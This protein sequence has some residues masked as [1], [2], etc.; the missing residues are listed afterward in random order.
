MATVVALAVLGVSG[1]AFT[2]SAQAPTPLPPERLSWYGDPGA[3]DVSGIWVRTGSAA[4]LTASGAQPGSVEGWTPWPPPL[5]QA[6]L[7]NWRTRVADNAAGNRTDDPVSACLPPGMPR[8]IT[9][10]NSP[11]QIIQTPGRVV[12][13][14]DGAPIRRIWL[15]GRPLPKLDD[16]ESFSNGTASGRYESKDLVIDTAGLKDEPIDSTGVPHSDE[17]RITERYRRTDATTLS[18]EVTL[19]DPAA[20]AQPMTAVVTY[21][22][23]EDPLWEPKEFIC[24]PVTNYHP[25]L[26]AH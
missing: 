21:K 26:Y 25:E 11:L 23:L 14:R 3:P 15:D 18:V 16:L 13:Y 12:M 5:K 9:G 2:A 19:T 10:T 22:A 4:Q 24:T 6:F 1:L 8:F 17:L 7:A 20:Y